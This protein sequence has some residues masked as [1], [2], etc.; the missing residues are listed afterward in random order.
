MLD[1]DPATLSAT[2]EAI[3]Q[4]HQADRSVDMV[5]S[6]VYAGAIHRLHIDLVFK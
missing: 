3:I 1:K 5:V 6:V 2:E 4:Q